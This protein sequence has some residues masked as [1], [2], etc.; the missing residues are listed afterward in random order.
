[1]ACYSWSHMNRILSISLSCFWFCIL[2]LLGCPGSQGAWHHCLRSWESQ[3]PS[4]FVSSCCTVAAHTS[5]MPVCW[6]S[7]LVSQLE[8]RRDDQSEKTLTIDTDQGIATHWS[9]IGFDWQELQSLSEGEFLED[10]WPYLQCSLVVHQSG[11]TLAMLLASC[12]LRQLLALQLAFYLYHE[13]FAGWRW[14]CQ[15]CWRP[16][17]VA[18]WWGRSSWRRAPALKI[19]SL[20]TAAAYH[21]WD[22]WNPE[23]RLRWAQFHSS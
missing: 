13:A 3:S 10:T 11:P 19:Q 8:N 18:L 1:M 16:C 21:S 4:R 17:T 15:A 6:D 23:W 22:P 9:Q 5:G 14:A 20:Q 7:H 12:G 2:Q